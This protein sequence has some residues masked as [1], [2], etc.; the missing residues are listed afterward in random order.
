MA[1]RNAIVGT[2][3]ETVKRL[4]SNMLAVLSLVVILNGLFFWSLRILNDRQHIEFMA[5]L[6]ACTPAAYRAIP[7][8]MDR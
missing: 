4:D 5:A 6:N 2:V 7:G 8:G 3:G 1:D